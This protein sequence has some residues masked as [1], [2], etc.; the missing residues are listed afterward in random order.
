MFV[1]FCAIHSTPVTGELILF[2]HTVVNV[3]ANVKYTFY[4]FF[5]FFAISWTTNKLDQMHNRCNNVKGALG[6]DIEG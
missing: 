3:N 4:F 2:C 5:F 1:S 6:R